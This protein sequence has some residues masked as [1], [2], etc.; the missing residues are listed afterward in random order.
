MQPFGRRQR[1]N[2]KQPYYPT[3]TSMP[4]SIAPA[5]GK[6]QFFHLGTP[7]SSEHG[8]ESS[9]GA[10]RRPPPARVRIGGIP[11][12]DGFDHPGGRVRIASQTRQSVE[13]GHIPKK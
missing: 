9:D 2:G 11:G 10:A 7:G 8:N 1:E 3:P 12:G 13:C 5:V 4:T 6:P